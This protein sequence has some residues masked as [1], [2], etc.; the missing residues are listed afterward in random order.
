MAKKMILAFNTVQRLT[1]WLVTVAFAILVLTGLTLFIPWIGNLAQGSAGQ[2]LR[3]WHRFGFVIGVVAVLIY[4]IFAPKSLFGSLKRIFRWGKNEFGWLKAAP[5]Y[6]FTG[7]EEKMP[8][9]DKFNAGQKLWYLVVVIGGLILLITGLLMWFGQGTISSGL[10]RISALLHSLTAIVMVLF[11][12]VHFHLA[13]VHPLM[14]DSL[15]SMRF[16]YLPEQFV[17]SHHARWYEEIK[18]GKS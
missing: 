15:N 11:F 1:H 4:L 6:Y 10:F 5:A 14:K 12:M 8:P 7:D 2:L 17:K 16:G 9:Q 3:Q 13:V 18:A